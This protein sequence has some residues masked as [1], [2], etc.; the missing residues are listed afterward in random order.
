MYHTFFIHS[1]MDGRLGCFHV[2]ALGNSATMNIGVHVPFLFLYFWLCLVFPAAHMLS[3]VLA[4]GGCS[5]ARCSGFSLQWLPLWQSSGSSAGS[6]VVARG[7]SFPGHEDSYWTRNPTRVPCIGRWILNHWTTREV[8]VV[9][10][11]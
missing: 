11:L 10:F 6:I 7:L 8:P 2:L 5:S 9:G 4:T 1:S 3:R